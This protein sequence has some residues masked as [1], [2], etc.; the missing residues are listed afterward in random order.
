[1]R[2]KVRIHHPSLKGHL[3]S[4]GTAGTLEGGTEGSVESQTA[5]VSSVERPSVAL[6]VEL[7]TALGAVCG[8]FAAAMRPDAT[9]ARERLDR[10]YETLVTSVEAF[11]EAIP[12]A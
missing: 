6:V 5:P 2:T 9:G 12:K 4:E 3:K 8:M 10:N 1:M 7:D 11:R